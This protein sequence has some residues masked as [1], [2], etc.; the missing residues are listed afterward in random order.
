MIIGTNHLES[1]VE[2]QQPKQIRQRFKIP[3]RWDSEQMQFVTRTK[4]C[5]A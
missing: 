1:E 2:K 5:E 4:R 3:L